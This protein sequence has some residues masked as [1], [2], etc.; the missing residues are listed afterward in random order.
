MTGWSE[1]LTDSIMTEIFHLKKWINFE[2]FA[3]LNVRE[4]FKNFG[5]GPIRENFWH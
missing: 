1:N 4:M 5:S 2:E 3:K